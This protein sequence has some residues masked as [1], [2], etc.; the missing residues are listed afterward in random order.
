MNY[1]ILRLLFVMLKYICLFLYLCCVVLYLVP[2]KNRLMCD[3]NFKLL[4]HF[5]VAYC[6]RVYR[7][8]AIGDITI[9]DCTKLRHGIISCFHCFFDKV[10]YRYVSVYMVILKVLAIF[11]LKILLF[12]RLLLS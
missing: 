9:H 10:R 6:Y 4:V 3:D 5:N 1:F 2:L 8:K 11:I 7:Y 12:V